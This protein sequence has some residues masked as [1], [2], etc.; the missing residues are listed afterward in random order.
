VHLD[1]PGVGRNLQEHPAV[2]V[3]PHVNVPTLTSDLGPIAIAREA[4]RFLSA[5]RGALTQPVGNAQAFVRTRAD[6]PAPNVQIIFSPTAFDHHETGVTVYRRPAATM[7][8]GLCRIASR[9][10]IRLRSGRPEDAPVIDYALLGDEDDV[11]QL[12]EGVRFARRLYATKAFGRYVLGERMPGDP[13]Q[14]DAE[15]RATIRRQSFLMYHPCG[16]C[17]MG[18]DEQAVVGADL[19]VRGVQGLWVADASIMPTVPAGNINATCLMIG[20]KASDLISGK[21]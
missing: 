12:A 10:A 3:S 11:G 14:S 21:T 15:L 16:T 6:L 13:Q 17:R 5:R 8:V 4:W 1:A 18:G 19:R 7:A 20:E 9:G 2:I